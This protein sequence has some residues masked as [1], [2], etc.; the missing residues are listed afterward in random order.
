MQSWKM[1]HKERNKFLHLSKE[2]SISCP[3]V[4]LTRQ[5]AIYTYG[6]VNID[7]RVTF[8]KHTQLRFWTTVE[9]IS[10]PF[11]RIIRSIG[12]WQIMSCR[13][14]GCIPASNIP[15]WAR[16]L[17]NISY[18][19]LCLVFRRGQRFRVLWFSIIMDYIKIVHKSSAFLIHVKLPMMFATKG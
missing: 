1:S 10:M 16:I 15:A 5:L 18:S 11:L 3:R 14:H 7:H 8:W 4:W 17:A 19:S 2:T 12:T 13:R 6:N 9:E